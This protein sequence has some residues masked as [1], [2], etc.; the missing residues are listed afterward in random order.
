MDKLFYV[1]G[2]IL[3]II[4]I[5]LGILTMNFISGYGY[6]PTNLSALMISTGVIIMILF[7]ITWI[8]DFGKVEKTFTYEIR[9]DDIEMEKLK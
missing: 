2:I 8:Y 1:F 9:T 6:N 5:I 4:L 7:A 3:G